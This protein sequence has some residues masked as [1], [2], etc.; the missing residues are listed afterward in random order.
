MKTKELIELIKNNK[1]ILITIGL[2]AI[3]TIIFMNQMMGLMFKAQLLQD[4][5]SLCESY[6][7][8]GYI[9]LNMSQLNLSLS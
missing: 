7:K 1:S 3:G 8:P 4:P 5:C 2:V 6:I 9:P